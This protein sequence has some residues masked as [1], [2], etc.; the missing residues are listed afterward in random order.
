M[1]NSEFSPLL[2]IL[3]LIGLFTFIGIAL[4]DF[5]KKKKENQQKEN[6]RLIH[7]FKLK[8]GKEYLITDLIKFKS[9][10]SF[11]D[12]RFDFYS[13]DDD[14]IYSLTTDDGAEISTN[15]CFYHLHNM[16]ELA[17]PRYNNLLNRFFRAYRLGNIGSKFDFTEIPLESLLTHGSE[18]IRN[19]I[20][21]KQHGTE[22][23]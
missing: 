12:Y 22:K 7:C 20:K 3:S 1:T 13:S 14:E 9:R 18:K 16:R 4:F 6:Q 8:D 5:F 23:S 17:G 19:Y 2:S 10:S 11:F 21:E 15:I